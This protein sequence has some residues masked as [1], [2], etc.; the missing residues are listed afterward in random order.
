MRSEIAPRY[1][2]RSRLGT[3]ERGAHTHT[4]DQEVRNERA[5]FVYR[6]VQDKLTGTSL[7][8]PPPPRRGR[9][10]WLRARGRARPLNWSLTPI[11][12][13]P[14]KDFTESPLTVPEQ[15]DK[16][17]LQATSLEN[18]CQCFSGWCVVPRLPD[19][20]SCANAMGCRQVCI[21]VTSS[22]AAV[23]GALWDTLHAL[24][25]LLYTLT[26]GRSSLS[27]LR[28]EMYHSI[29]HDRG[30]DER[31]VAAER[32]VRGMLRPRGD[33]GTWGFVAVETRRAPR[34]SGGRVP[35]TRAR[36]GG[37]G[38]GLRG[39]DGARWAGGRSVMGRRRQRWGLGG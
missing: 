8:P 7:V 4:E 25:V 27:S 10:P 6:R 18:L 20:R 30:R 14:G 15:V 17:I 33:A 39:R 1:G 19:H 13:V 22:A 31:G 28:Y 37:G 12:L 23:G 32:L 35:R 24:D 2:S 36:C 3:D 16:L 29:C 11:A 38:G 9:G 5:L 21:L 34:E 26:L